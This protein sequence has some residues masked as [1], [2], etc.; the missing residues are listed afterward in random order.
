MLQRDEFTL[1][2]RGWISFGQPRR[3]GGESLQFVCD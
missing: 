1:R 2:K 3:A